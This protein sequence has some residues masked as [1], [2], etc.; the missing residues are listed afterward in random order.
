M[1]VVLCGMAFLAVLVMNVVVVY[2]YIYTSSRENIRRTRR[3]RH[4][5][6]Q[7]HLEYFHEILILREDNSGSKV[8]CRRSLFRMLIANR[9]EAESSRVLE[10]KTGKLIANMQ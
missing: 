4:Y 9:P 6:T 1:I 8:Y 2:V 3:E 7:I 5:D 10:V